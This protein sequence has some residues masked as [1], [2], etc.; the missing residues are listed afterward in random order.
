[1][2]P[3]SVVVAPDM[4][5]APEDEE[6]EEDDELES[7]LLPPPPIP[8]SL[9]PAPGNE[10]SAETLKLHQPATVGSVLTYKY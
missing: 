6:A 1:V 7:D 4:K 3:Y 8:P 10:I 5:S 2:A 9:H